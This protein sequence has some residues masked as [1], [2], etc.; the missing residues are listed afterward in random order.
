[1][2]TR[3][4]SATR[5]VVIGDGRPTVIIGE[6]INPTGRKKLAEAMRKG[7]FDMVRRDAIAQVEAGAAIIDVNAGVPGVN[8]VELFPRVVQAAMEAVDAPLSLDSPSPEAVA[9]ALKIYKGRPLINS[10]TGEEKSMKA[11]LPLI[12]EYDACAVAMLQGGEGIAPDPE[13]RLAVAR[14][15]IERAEAMGISRDRLVV[16]CMAMTVGA[17]HHAALVTLET[18]RRLRDEY[19]V[20]LVLG[21]SNISFGLPDREVLNNAFL[22]MA[23]GAGAT[24]LIT[25]AARVRPTVLATDLLLGR[26]EYAATYI[27]EFRK[28]GAAGRR[29]N[30][31]DGAG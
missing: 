17:D 16:D 9:A 6:Q 4:S 24:C 1:M 22:P 14:K 11:V 3:V 31:G 20:N 23:I 15:L 19:G 29:L 30:R 10:V 28:R 13:G 5:E 8:E 18:M 12:K 7:D 21:A 26:D 25:N 27:G 2:E